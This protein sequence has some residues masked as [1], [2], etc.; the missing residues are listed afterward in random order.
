MPFRGIIFAMVV[1]FKK[2]NFWLLKMWKFLNFILK[3]N[4][5]LGTLDVIELLCD[6][7]EI[8]DYVFETALAQSIGV[9]L[10]SAAALVTILASADTVARL[11]NSAHH[12]PIICQTNF[13]PQYLY[14]SIFHLD[15]KLFELLRLG[16]C[17]RCK[18]WQCIRNDK[19]LK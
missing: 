1:R 7:S 8:H 9:E 18:W 10:T 17:G 2:M 16:V 13:Y 19:K 3:K 14:H 4:E 15:K 12:V 6:Y 11:S 5:K